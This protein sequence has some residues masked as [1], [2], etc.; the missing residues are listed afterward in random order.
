MHAISPTPSAAAWISTTCPVRTTPVLR[1]SLRY[2]DRV[3]TVYPTT[4]D[5]WLR[6]LLFVPLLGGGASIYTG[7]VRADTTTV[8]ISAA[9]LAAYVLVMVTLGWPIR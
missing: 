4:I 7:L 6:P 8:V 5:W 2:T 1:A 3:L 9:V